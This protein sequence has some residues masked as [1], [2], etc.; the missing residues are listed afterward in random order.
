MELKKIKSKI[1]E[2]LEETEKFDF[3]FLASYTQKQEILEEKKEYIYDYLLE[4]LG[5]ERVKEIPLEKIW[6]DAKEIVDPKFG[7]LSEKRKMNGFYLQE[8]M[9]EYVSI[10]LEYILKIGVSNEK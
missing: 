2:L 9:H 3:P 8:I 7:M 10:I 5:E 6:K 1:D 4:V